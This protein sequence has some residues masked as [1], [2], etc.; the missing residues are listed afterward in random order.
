M[1][2]SLFDKV[3]ETL[4]QVFSCEF[5]EISESTLFT[6]H[7]RETVSEI[8]INKYQI[9]NERHGAHCITILRVR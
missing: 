6:E 3:A 7:I 1:P 2:E 9:L 5:C 8:I 4:A